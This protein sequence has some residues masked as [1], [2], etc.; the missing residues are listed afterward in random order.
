MADTPASSGRYLR[1]LAALASGVLLVPALLFVMA[2]AIMPLDAIAYGNKAFWLVVVAGGIAAAA[3]VVRVNPSSVLRA[4]SL[5]FVVVL[6]F[7]LVWL[8]WLFIAGAA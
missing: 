3:L 7:L 8:A 5:G 2:V 1:M 6:C 4:S